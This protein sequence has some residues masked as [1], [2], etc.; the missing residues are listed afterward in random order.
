MFEAF[1]AAKKM[2]PMLGGGF[3]K[4]ASQVQRGANQAQGFARQAQSIQNSYVPYNNNRRNRCRCNNRKMNSGVQG[5]GYMGRNGNR[6]LAQGVIG[7]GY[8]QPPNPNAGRNGNR[9]LAQG[10]IGTGYPRPPTGSGQP[11][12]GN[13]QQ[14]NMRQPPKVRSGMQKYL[15]SATSGRPFYRA[16][17]AVM[18]SGWF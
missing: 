16:L 13:G 17:E 9:V 1:G 11:L 5:T 12:N 8:P 7:T 14:V 4:L 10:V 18:P 6:V 3:A 15:N 2:A